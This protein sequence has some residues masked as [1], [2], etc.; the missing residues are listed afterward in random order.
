MKFSCYYVQ[1][2]KEKSGTIQKRIIPSFIQDG[3]EI[4]PHKTL[5]KGEIELGF[6]KLSK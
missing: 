1:T 2:I 3:K 5:N 4:F 6:C